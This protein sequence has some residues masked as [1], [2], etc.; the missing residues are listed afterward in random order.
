M[1]ERIEIALPVA[2]GT[3]NVFLIPIESGHML[4]DCGMT[5]PPPGLPGDIRQIAITHAHPDHC[6]GAA[7]VR[8]QTGAPL[9]MHW[10]EAATLAGLR[11]AEGWLEREERTLTRAGVPEPMRRRFQTAALRIRR[12]FPNAAADGL[13]QDGDTIPTALGPMRVIHTPGHAAGHLCFYFP[14]R[15]LLISGDQLVEHQAPHIDL[16]AGA[17][18]LDQYRESLHRLARL[19]A[20]WVYPSH[21]APFQGHRE[22][23]AA[24]LEHCNNKAGDIRRW[25]AAG[26]HTAHEL[27]IGYWG[28][29]M[30]PFEHRCAVREMMCYMEQE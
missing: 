6:G 24:L 16:D 2:P 17:N 9:L 22:R 18:A 21:G 28:R 15:R 13:L 4:I 30:N 3:V 14:E 7:R 26:F 23:I 29:P 25:R 10:R 1:I 11:D 5:T 20:G 12:F 27:A 19:D 8:D